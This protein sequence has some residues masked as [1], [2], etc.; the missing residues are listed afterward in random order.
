MI[1]LTQKQMKEKYYQDLHER[2][3]HAHE[4]MG[5]EHDI[6]CAWEMYQYGGGCICGAK[7]K[8]R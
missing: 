2:M 6:F 3:L 4:E 5:K 1:K 8:R 7:K